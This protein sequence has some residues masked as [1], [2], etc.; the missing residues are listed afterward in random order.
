MAVLI[1][2]E[3]CDLSELKQKLLKIANG[4]WML[5][6]KEIPLIN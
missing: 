1:E 3:E 6:E 2:L 5:K 4:T